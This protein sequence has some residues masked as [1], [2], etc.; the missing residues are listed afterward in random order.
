MRANDPIHVAHPDVLRTAVEAAVLAPST[1]NSQPWKFRIQGSKLEIYADPRRYLPVLDAERRQQIQSCGCALYNARISV[2][3]QGYEDDVTV[4]LADA[5]E[6][7]HLATLQLG[8]H[9]ISSDADLALM[10]AIPLRHTNRRAF[11]KRPIGAEHT[12]ALI[13]AAADEGVTM[14]RLSPDQKHRIGTLIDQ[15]DRLQYGDPAFRA[16]ISNWLVAFGSSRRDGIPFV[17]KE[18]GSA[19]PF[20]VV[21]ALRS[22]GLGSEFG[23]LE[24]GLVNSAPVVLAIGTHGDTT[25]DWFQC[26]EALQAVLLRATALGLSAA[27]FNQVLEIPGLRSEVVELLPGIGFPQMVF[28]LGVPEESIHRAAPRRDL[29]DVLEIVP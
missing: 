9:R 13:Q 8:E 12:D 1:H 27:F 23:K 26:G 11:A 5:L 4:M 15:A 25:S 22:P 18:F 3:A 28:R 6:P 2:R 29:S 21:R 10:R 7:E 19:L 20:T 14:V 16:E 17:E 24:E